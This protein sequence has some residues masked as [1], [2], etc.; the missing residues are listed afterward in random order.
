[1]SAKSHSKKVLQAIDRSATPRAWLHTHATLVSAMIDSGCGIVCEFW[2]LPNGR[3][4]LLYATPA[5]WDV[6][7]PVT[8]EAR[9]DLT[10]TAL[11]EFAGIPP[12]PQQH[13]GVIQ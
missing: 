3:A 5:G 9:T 1:M 4:V 11:A 7:R 12:S 13:P 8:P 10:I 6:L 2:R